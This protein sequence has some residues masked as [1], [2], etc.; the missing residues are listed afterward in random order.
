[1]FRSWSNLSH[2]ND[3][4][5]TEAVLKAVIATKVMIS[6]VITSERVNFKEIIISLLPI[7]VVVPNFTNHIKWCSQAKLAPIRSHRVF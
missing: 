2:E 5:T 6:Y 4:A 1:M 7:E 3:A